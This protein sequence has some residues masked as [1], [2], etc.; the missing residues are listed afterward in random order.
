MARKFHPEGV[1]PALIT[2]FNHKF[3]VD[4]EALKRHV[5]WLIDKGVNA[6]VPC[7]TTGEFVNLSVEERMRIIETVVDEVNGRIPVIAGSGAASTKIAL[8]FTKHAEDVGADAALIVSPFYLKPTDKEIF[9]HYEKIASSVDIPILLYNIPQCTG[10]H[11][12]WWVVEGLAEIDNIVGIKDSSGNMPYFMTLIEKLYGKFSLICG[13]DEIV[14][15]ALVAGASGVI[16]ASANFIPEIWLKIYELVKNK[17]NIDEAREIHRKYQTVFRFI[18]RFGGPLPVKS[19]LKMMGIDVGKA[20]RPLM[21]GG[22]MPYEVEEELRR[23]LE[24]LSLIPK[25]KIELE[26]KPGKTFY[27]ERV[28]V[29]LTPMKIKDFTLRVGEGFASPGTVDMAHIDLML[30]LKDG[31][32]GYAFNEALKKPEKGHEPKIASLNGIEILPK[33]LLIPT[34]TVRTEKHAKLTYGSAMKGA[35][36]AIVEAVESNLIPKDAIDMLVIV[37][38]I[39]VHPTA[40][41]PKRIMLNNYK[42]M[43]YAI[44]RAL[45]N[46]PTVE[47]LL[48]GKNSA[49]HPFKYAP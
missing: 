33:T 17:R 19:S 12:P 4:F 7:G 36:K 35:T 14:L 48:E 3:E 44:K 9:E 47:E 16:L 1:I 39:F 41:N 18:A 13:H 30:G 23:R 34:V 28:A 21:I 45:E 2:P 37:A 20:R 42:A 29:P 46:R 22:L 40:C 27:S 38:H 10:V 32:V 11:I 31:P 26:I 15:P 24:S 8:E 5:E 49:R 6:I 25:K 43:N